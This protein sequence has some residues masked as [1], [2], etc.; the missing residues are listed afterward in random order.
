MNI[1]IIAP[2]HHHNFKN[3]ALPEYTYFDTPLGSLEVNNRLIKDIVSRFPC[4]LNNEVFE[5]EH[6]IEVQLPFIQNIFSPYIIQRIRPWLIRTAMRPRT[7]V[8]R[9]T[10][11]AMNIIKGGEAERK[12]QVLEGSIFKCL[13]PYNAHGLT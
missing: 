8:K 13:S 4:L 11:R 1:F 7:A 9:Q 10:T 5:N 12:N 2:S 6:S 3:I